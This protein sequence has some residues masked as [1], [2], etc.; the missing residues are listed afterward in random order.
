MTAATKHIILDNAKQIFARD[1][2]EGLSMRTLSKES[3]VG[4]S[5]IYHFFSDKDVLLGHLFRL[6]ST[7]LGI[8]RLKLPQRTN[9]SDMMMDRIVFQFQHIEDV[10]FVLK[11]YLH[12]RGEFEKTAGGYVPE[13]AYL[14]IEEVLEKGVRS[15]ELAIPADQIAKESK[16]I[17]HAINGFLLEF[18]PTKP[19]KDELLML[20]AT[21]HQF[22]MRSLTNKEG[23]VKETVS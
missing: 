23:I 21:L 16:V 1:G 2:Y 14:H 22:I 3:G 15:G 11:Y 5:S 18:Y 7:E 9:V 8:E 4:L 12:Y 13:K 20:A 19:K 10:V 6:T 17:T